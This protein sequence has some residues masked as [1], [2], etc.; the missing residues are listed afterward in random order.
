[1]SDDVRSE[2]AMFSPLAVRRLGKVR[3]SYDLLREAL[4]LPPEVKVVR[5]VDW[6]EQLNEGFLIVEGEGLPA[7]PEGDM[8]PIVDAEFI[9]SAED[10]WVFSRWAL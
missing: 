2:G 10:E 9:K 4:R 6:G 5:L 1:M 8:I 3:V 7:I